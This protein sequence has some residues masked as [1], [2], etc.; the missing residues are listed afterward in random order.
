[1][2][3]TKRVFTLLKSL[4]DEQVESIGQWLNDGDHLIDEK[5]KQW[6]KEFEQD[7]N[8]RSEANNRGTKYGF[9]DENWDRSTGDNQLADDLRIFGLTPPASLVEVKKARNREI[10]K[11]HPDRFTADMGKLETAKEILQIY[12]EVY[13]RLAKHY[14][15]QKQN[16]Q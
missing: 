4:V 15:N 2:S 13:E 5:L 14:S 9:E 6:E 8:G 16:R 7:Q 12:N 11:Y 1:M 10:K 3:V